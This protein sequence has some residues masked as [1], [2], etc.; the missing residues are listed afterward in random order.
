MTLDPKTDTGIL[1][2]FH[3]GKYPF[4]DVLARVVDLQKFNEVKDRLSLDTMKYTDSNIR[5]GN[6]IPAHGAMLQPFQLGN[7]IERGF[8]IFFQRSEWNVY[9]TAATQEG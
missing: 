2:V 4:Y 1:S 8:N 6:L 7:A 9:A 5:I 3:E